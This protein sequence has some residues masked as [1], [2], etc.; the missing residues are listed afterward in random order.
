MRLVPNFVAGR[1]YPAE[2]DLAGIIVDAGD[3]DFKVGDRVFGFIEV[4]LQRKIRQGSLT[5][6][7]RMPA[8]HLAP[9]PA[10]TSFTG[11]AG[12]TLAGETAYQALFEV[13][14]LEA[15]QSVFVNGGSSSVG[16]FAIQIAKAK[17]C[18]VVASASGKNEDFVKA[19]GADEA[20]HHIQANYC[21]QPGLILE[22]NIFSS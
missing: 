12:F 7:T 16:A 6:Y 19:L 2:N 10:N 4:D 22:E 20:S 1:P 21:K 18:R 5:E 15:G 14:Q 13:C 9:L 3:S 11:A 8:S 17:G